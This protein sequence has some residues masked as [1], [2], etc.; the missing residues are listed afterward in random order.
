ML[1]YEVSQDEANGC[2]IVRGG[3]LPG[4]KPVEIPINNAKQE[5]LKKQFISFFLH[6][7]DVEIGINYL[8]CISLNNHPR[9]NEGLFVGAL[10]VY[11]KCFQSSKSRIPVPE[12]TFKGNFPQFADCFDRFKQWRNKHYLHDENGMTQ[13]CAFLLI[14]PED[15]PA[16]FGGPPSV[17][18]NSAGVDYINEGQSLRG[19]MQATLDFIVGR[20]DAV[21]NEIEKEVENLTKSELLALKEAHIELATTNSPE[22][23][24]G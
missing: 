7:K 1:N 5:N 2:F 21:G 17:V 6:K 20:I 15:N 4:S 14:A 8:D 11:F 18:W 12:K 23:K 24:R 19:V 16:K 22:Q 10:S 9:A 3:I 13:T